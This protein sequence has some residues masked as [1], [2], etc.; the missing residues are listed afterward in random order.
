MKHSNKLPAA[1]QRKEIKR[2][3]PIWRFMRIQRVVNISLS[4]LIL[5]WTG[6]YLS[7]RPRLIFIISSFFTLYILLQPTVIKHIMNERHWLRIGMRRLH[8]LHDGESPQLQSVRLMPTNLAPLPLAVSLSWNRRAILITGITFLILL[9]LELWGCIVWKLD[10]NGGYYVFAAIVGPI[11]LFLLLILLLAL[12]YH[13]YFLRQ[14]IEVNEDGITTC[15]QGKECSMRWQDAR[16]FAQYSSSATGGRQTFELSNEQIIVRWSKEGIAGNYL[17]KAANNFADH[18]YYDTLIEQVNA[19]V[20]EHTH[21]PL[22]RLDTI[23]PATK[24]AR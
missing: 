8:I 1:A 6:Y 22:L 23:K 11:I 19:Q 16:L 9:L 7:T 10:G 12:A 3:D 24:P 5:S 4:I 2:T 14:R 17:L 15:Y 21:L 18:N 13:A 20:A